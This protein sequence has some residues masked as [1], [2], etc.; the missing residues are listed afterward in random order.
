MRRPGGYAIWVDPTMPT[1]ECD[2]FTCKHC[3]AVVVVEARCK[4]EEAGG[5]CR[6]CMAPVCP[7]CADKPCT[8]FEK[9]LDAIERRDRLC[10]AAAEE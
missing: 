7:A 1:K 10:R 3:N 6:M 9:K 4:P 8:P 2:T 5:Y